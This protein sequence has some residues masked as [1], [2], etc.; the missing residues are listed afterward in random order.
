M[1]L[2]VS[3]RILPLAHKR[4][5]WVMEGKLDQSYM[6]DSQAPEALAVNMDPSFNTPRSTWILDAGEYAKHERLLAS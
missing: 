6:R 3:R 4:G 5:K 2:L 1:M